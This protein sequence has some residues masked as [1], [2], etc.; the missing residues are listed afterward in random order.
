MRNTARRR[1]SRC[2][3]KISDTARAIGARCSNSL[4]A[5]TKA[6]VPLR[7]RHAPAG[8]NAKIDILSD[9]HKKVEGVMGE[10][11]VAKGGRAGG[12][13][14]QRNLEQWPQKVNCLK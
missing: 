14:H 6:L 9:A 1:S 8:S 13:A 11:T 10:Y 3:P 7:A 5:L 12:S 2:R 4:R